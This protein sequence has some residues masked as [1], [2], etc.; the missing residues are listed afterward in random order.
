ML[1]QNLLGTRSIG[2][3]HLLE[4]LS[5]Q[6]LQDIVPHLELLQLQ[7]GEI[8]C[9]SGQ[10]L[11]HAYFPTSAVVSLL[12]ILE[13]GAS[14]EFGIV[15][16]DG[17]LGMALIMGGHTMPHQAI[18]QSQGFAYRL[19]AGIFKHEFK[20]SHQ[21]Q[22][23]LLRYVQYLF[24][25]VAQMAGCNRRHSIEQR[26][27]RLLLMYLDRA[28]SNE[29]HMTHETI[30][31]MLGVRREGVSQAAGKLRCRGAITYNRGRISALDREILE[32]TACECY[33]MVNQE[34]QRLMPITRK[35][36]VRQPMS[37]L[38]RA[39]ETTRQSVQFSRA[40][41]IGC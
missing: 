29:L 22:E 2:K 10:K 37:Y 12:H 27:A 38:G 20:R 24:I 8:I 32:E 28:N 30:A 18:V 21:M 19:P 36:N 23:L 41:A 17:M 13:D 3:N 33:D 1:N 11:T 7:P 14:T 35:A 15:S 6:A 40:D 39:R 4:A 34:Y 5:A 25:Q 16:N 26:L 9:D 31:T